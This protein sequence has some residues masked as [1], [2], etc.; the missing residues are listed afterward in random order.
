MFIT[1]NQNALAMKKIKILFI[2]FSCLITGCGKDQ[3]EAYYISEME[4]LLKEKLNSDYKVGNTQRATHVKSHGLVKGYFKVVDN[5]P[6]ELKVGIFN[7][8]KT[9]E[10]WLRFSNARGKWQ[11]DK[12]KDFRGLSLKLL[13]DKNFEETSV[14]FVLQSFPTMALGTVK[15]FRDGMYYDIKRNRL[16]AALAFIFT[17]RLNTLLA[18]NAGR[19]IHSS[20]LD[21]EYWSATPYKFGDRFVKYKLLPTSSFKSPLLDD[22]TD[23]YLSENMISHLKSNNATFDFLIQF[24]KDELNTPLENAGIEWKEDVSPF[25]KVAEINIPIQDFKT[26]DREVLQMQMAFDP[27]NVPNVHE[28]VGG[29]NRARKAIYY[30][31]SQFRSERDGIELTTPQFNEHD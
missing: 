13:T 8:E 3:T 2:F 6:E 7:D 25:I 10:T 23:D 27:S 21:I 31:L 19:E 12:V 14:D 22:L 29:L 30:V 1:Y 5:L 11:S 15:D 17:G 16:Y 24:F 4:S 9:F 20:P 26:K 18:F 28:P